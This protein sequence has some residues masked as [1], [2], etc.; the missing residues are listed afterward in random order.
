MMGPDD[1]VPNHI[2]ADAA[3]S[4]RQP[5]VAPELRSL[6]ASTAEFGFGA[7]PD[8]EGTS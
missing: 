3:P 5:W 8:S 1:I 4:D 7:A 2:L 6:A